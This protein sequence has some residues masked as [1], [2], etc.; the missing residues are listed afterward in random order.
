ML[1]EIVKSWSSSNRCWGPQSDCFVAV[2]SLLVLV[3][4]SACV[5]PTERARQ[6]QLHAPTSR[7][8]AYTSVGPRVTPQTGPSPVYHWYSRVHETH[9]VATSLGL[10]DANLW[11][12]TAPARSLHEAVILA[13]PASGALRRCAEFTVDMQGRESSTPLREVADNGSKA[14][15]QAPLSLVLGAAAAGVTRLEFCHLSVQ[16]S[17]ANR[18]Q[19]ARFALLALLYRAQTE[20]GNDLSVLLHTSSGA[21]S[22]GSVVA[23]GF[24]ASREVDFV[25]GSFTMFRDEM[26]VAAAPAIREDVVMT[27]RPRTARDRL[28]NC[29]GMEVEADATLLRVNTS[30]R[31]EDGS[32]VEYAAD[33]ETFVRLALSES[34]TLI[35]CN[36]RAQITE[37]HLA[38]LRRH[39][40]L[41]LALLAE[42]AAD[43]EVRL[44]PDLE[45]PPGAPRPRGDVDMVLPIAQDAPGRVL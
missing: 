30:G 8:P 4:V 25:Q 23:R 6:S 18:G 1:E 37:R 13:E 15:W 44:F 28:Q 3:G 24:D 7:S 39:A 16:L 45:L 14:Q 22:R 33:I 11:L 21:A 29:E 43:G 40:L 36:R 9:I 41:T 20:G 2:F 10:G 34:V 38:E 32:S 42:R 26:V 19:L 27:L 31:A 12:I 35:Y 5:P 17:D